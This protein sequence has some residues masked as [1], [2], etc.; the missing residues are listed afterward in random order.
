MKV[1]EGKTLSF[2]FASHPVESARLRWKAK[3]TFPGGAGAD[4]VLPIRVVDGEENPVAAG[5]LELAGKTLV[6]ADGASSISYADFIRGKHEPA[7]W[8]HR[9][10]EKPVPG[11]LTFE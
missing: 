6:V 8:L 7:L 4:A 5:R 1:P 3:L 11:L 2:T 9:D 10:G